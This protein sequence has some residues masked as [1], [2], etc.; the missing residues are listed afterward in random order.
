MIQSWEGLIVSTQLKRDNI[1][2]EK[3]WTKHYCL[4]IIVN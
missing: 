4:V 2:K 1:G 3:K